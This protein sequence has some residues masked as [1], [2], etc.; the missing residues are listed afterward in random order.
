MSKQPCGVTSHNRYSMQLGTTL[1]SLSQ[2]A[3]NGL[4]GDWRCSKFISNEGKG[5]WAGRAIGKQS[6]R[7]L[8]REHGSPLEVWGNPAAGYANT[9]QSPQV[10][11]SG[12]QGP[13]RS[14]VAQTTQ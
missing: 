2:K 8:C 14:D 6:R 10:E 4:A 1:N 13:F 7:R 11:G 3:T 5:N 12:Q 9:P